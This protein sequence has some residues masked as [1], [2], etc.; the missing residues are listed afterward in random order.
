MGARVRV[1]IDAK[2]RWVRY[3]TSRREILLTALSVS[4]TLPAHARAGGYRKKKKE[5]GPRKPRQIV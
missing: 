2:S 4:E 1:E 5:G 3:V